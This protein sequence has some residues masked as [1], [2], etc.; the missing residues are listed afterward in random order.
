MNE[1][2]CKMTTRK[3]IF[4]LA[5]VLAAALI[6]APPMISAEKGSAAPAASAANDSS[7]ALELPKLPTVEKADLAPSVLEL[8]EKAVAAKAALRTDYLNRLA[9]GAEP[10]VKGLVYLLAHNNAGVRWAAVL[11][12]GKTKGSKTALTA[13]RAML[14]DSNWGV[15]E[16]AA[17]SLGRIGEPSDAALL[18]ALAENDS[19]NLVKLAAQRAAA[20]IKRRA[21]NP[22]AAAKKSPGMGKATARPANI[23]LFP[24]GT[25]L[26]AE[27]PGKRP[28]KV[29]EWVSDKEIK[30]S[31][32]RL[33]DFIYAKIEEAGLEASGQASNGAFLRRIWLD[34]SGVIPPSEIA[35]EHIKSGVNRARVID[36]LLK[37]EEYLDHWSDLWTGWLIGR[38]N[39]ESRE[40]TRLRAWV[41]AA[42]KD[43][44]PYDVMVRELIATEGPTQE[45]GAAEYYIRF[46]LDSN[47]M[48][49]RTSRTFLGLP[50]QCAQCHDHKSEPWLQ[51]QFYGVKAFFDSVRRVEINE[52]GDDGEEVYIGSYLRD[53][54]VSKARVP[55]KEVDVPPTFLD[56]Q[57][58]QNSSSMSGRLAYAN[59]MTDGDNP[60]FAK[61]TVNRIWDYFTGAGIVDPIDWFGVNTIPS[62]PELLDWLAEDFVRHGYNLRYLTR[63]ILNSEMYQRSAQTSDLNKNDDYFLTHARIRPL[64]A[65]QLFYSLLEATN[66]ASRQTRRGQ[67]VRDMKR[68]YLR[69]F[70]FTFGND[71]MEEDEM[72]NP[73]IAQALM[74]L[75]GS[76]VNDGI[77]AKEGTRLANIL[78]RQT[79]TQRRL[80]QIYLATLSRL[81]T[82][83]ERSYFRSYMNGYKR[84]P[85]RAYEDLYWSLLNSAEF[86]SN[87]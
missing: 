37:S 87:H 21:A 73:T 18:T 86:A 57:E 7:A 22:N 75:N 41:R 11:A 25:K 54:N 55:E 43:N 40:A 20:A 4:V 36:N 12:L 30:A 49:S 58:Y 62:H 35:R 32:K 51:E 68:R 67:N 82:G 79:E 74:M 48:T 47:E 81:P 1:G 23:S 9:A 8:V 13:V 77:V 39:P 3:W 34:L 17:S 61:A 10:S 31:A 27:G 85:K 71:E 26:S 69:Q 46:D 2:T 76:L 38:S 19:Q 70:T 65:E 64:T 15:R 59:W 33:D 66:I 44:M 6:A 83:A 72:N 42:L 84:D 14:A 52:E 53:R 56:G 80:E 16:G 50:L 63:A 45:I 5:A 28:R 29:A 24:P 78:S 60:Y